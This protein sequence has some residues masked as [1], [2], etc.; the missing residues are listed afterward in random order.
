MDITCTKRE[1]DDFEG[2]RVPYMSYGLKRKAS[3]TLNPGRFVRKFPKSF[4]IVKAKHMAVSL[5]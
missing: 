2:S 1:P 4:S 3:F 5:G